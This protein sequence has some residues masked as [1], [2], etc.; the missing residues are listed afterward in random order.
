MI[1]RA[2][3]DERL[4][5]VRPN[6]AAEVRK[7]AWFQIRVQQW[8]AIFGAE[9]NVCQQMGESVGHKSKLRNGFCV[10]HGVA[11]ESSPQRKLWERRAPKRFKPRMGREKCCV[12]PWFSVAPAGAWKICGCRHPQLALWA[13]IARCSAA[14]SPAMS[15]N[16]FGFNQFVDPKILILT[17]HSPATS[18]RFS[19][20]NPHR[21]RAIVQ[22]HPVAILA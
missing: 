22:S 15:M 16:V 20:R 4:A 12:A 19:R 8:R 3:D 14:K 13:T 11:C 9:N 17:A 18:R 6:D 10:S 7:Q 21:D 5:V 2:V 1:G